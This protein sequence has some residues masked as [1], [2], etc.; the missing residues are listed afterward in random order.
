MK[1]LRRQL[2]FWW[3]PLVAA[4]IGAAGSI[5]AG[6]KAADAQSDANAANLENARL[7]REL[8]KEFA[9]HGVQWRVAD[10]QAAGVH[11]LYAMGANVSSAT[12]SSIPVMAETGRAEGIRG[13]FDQMGQGV[14]A[15]LE[16]YSNE[17]L[18]M[19]TFELKASEARSAIARNDAQ[20]ML[21]MARADQIKM[22]MAKD[23]TPSAASGVQVGLVKG[24]ADQQISARPLSPEITAGSH[25]GYREYNLGGSFKFLAP[26]NEEGWSE[27]MESVPWAMWPGIIADNVRHYGVG[28]IG[29]AWDWL[30]GSKLLA[31]GGKTTARS[32]QAFRDA[33]MNYLRRD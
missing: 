20:A 32:R 17:R 3:A 7:D 16:G 31:G 27:G 8:Q 5:I 12:P 23:A 9:Q 21:D 24:I 1:S 28:W 33:L 29:Q 15:G 25:P 14:R 2:G 6:N 10:A 19:L 30:G 11:P 22:Q 13:A 4:G 18:A 26:V